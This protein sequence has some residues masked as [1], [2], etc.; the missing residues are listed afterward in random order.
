[1]K[2]KL[3]YIPIIFLSVFLL[4]IIL[5]LS[6]PRS[7]SIIPYSHQAIEDNSS[8]VTIRCLNASTNTVSEVNLEDHL[9]GVLAAEMPAS[10]DPE[11]LKAQTVA[12]RSYI[13]SKLNKENPVHPNADICTNPTHC[14][15]WLSEAEAK[16]KWE[17]KEQNAY[18]QKL[19]AAVLA[20]T[21]EY[22][23]YDDMVVEA[24]FFASGGGRT[25]NSEDVWQASLPYLRSVENPE[26]VNNTISQ[27]T[28]TNDEFMQRLTS[29]SYNLQAITAPNFSDIIRTD[30]GSV[31]TINICGETFKGTEVRTI[32]GLKSANFTIAT[33]PDGV[34][35]NV[36]GSGHGVGMSQKG[37]N[38]MAKD[39]KKYTEILSHYYT[40]IQIVKM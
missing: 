39:G 8:F 26:P 5:G 13:L 25:E 17:P 36:I 16:S 35:F 33:D 18:W 12:A 23:T 14:K 21:G 34:T 19:Q 1:M 15:G 27:V 38:Q 9:V 11:A 30:G 3:I 32:F 10:Y 4:P 31:A 24:C 20:T 37:A 29:H 7:I 40:N 22:M 2:K 6:F 28:F